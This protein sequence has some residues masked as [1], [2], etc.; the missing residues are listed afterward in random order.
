MTIQAES[1]EQWVEEMVV[2]YRPDSLKAILADARKQHR[3][4]GREKT[5]AYTLLKARIVDLGVLNRGYD[6]DTAI[7]LLCDEL[8]Y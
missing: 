4:Q 7:S 2:T 6:Y 8:A 5:I 3:L 1:L